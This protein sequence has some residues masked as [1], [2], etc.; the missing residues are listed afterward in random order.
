MQ[1]VS[2]EMVATIEGLETKTSALE[3]Y[4]AELERQL[5]ELQGSAGNEE[6][7]RIRLEEKEKVINDLQVVV[8]GHEALLHDNR[9]V[10]ENLS[11]D[12]TE[13]QEKAQGL[14]E[15]IKELKVPD[16]HC[17]PLCA[18]PCCAASHFMP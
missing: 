2:K 10:M 13:A 17:S 15:E 5:A 9:L 8:Q 4:I 3:S 11:E 6:H 14:E 7:W 16:V 1:T 12:V 18:M